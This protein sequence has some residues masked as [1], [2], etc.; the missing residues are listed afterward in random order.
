MNCTNSDSFQMDNYLEVDQYHF[1]RMRRRTF[2]KLVDAIKN[3]PS[4]VHGL[5]VQSQ[6]AIALNRLGSME[7]VTVLAMRHNVSRTSVARCTARV[8]AAVIELL[9]T[10]V[11]VWPSSEERAF[12]AD[13]FEQKCG[14][15]N[16]VGIIDGC[17][18]PYLERPRVSG[19]VHFF[20]YKRQFATTFQGVCDNTRRLRTYIGGFPGNI[21]DS[22]QYNEM[23]LAKDPARFFDG[24][25]YL[26]GD[27]GYG[28]N[29]RLLTPF[30]DRSTEFNPRLRQ[31]FNKH[32]RS[33]RTLVEHSWGMLKQRFQY[34]RA[35][36]SRKTSFVSNLIRAAITINNFI[37]SCG[38]ETG[39]Q[40]EYP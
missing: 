16:I 21:R 36:R 18:F 26:L 15:P 19:S 30:M 13:K 1:L 38:E 32:L 27:L 20:S 8:C 17:Q 11:N 31:L 33:A 14:I 28:L 39:V 22:S 35:I 4:F 12:I 9:D 3:H 5:T 24:D 25:Q 10:K 37:L 29:P 7:T 40:G 23:S 2:D 34:L 6:V